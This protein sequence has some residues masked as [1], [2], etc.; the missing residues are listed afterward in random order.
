MP[1]GHTVHRTAND[2]TRKF[3]GK[4]LVIDSPQGRF[5]ADAA[6]VS[7]QVLVSAK[8]IGKQLF[9]RFQNDLVLRVHLG[10]YG[11]WNWVDLTRRSEFLSEPPKGQVRARFHDG[12]KLAELRGPTVCEVVPEEAAQ[13]VENRLG[14]DPINPDPTGSEQQRFVQRVL[15]SGQPIG[16]L[17]MDQSV[18][19]GVGNVYRA[20]LLFRAGLDPYMPG[21]S[22]PESVLVRLWEDSVKLL[23]VGVRH[24][25]MITRDELFDSKPLKAERNFVYKREGQGC[26]ECGTEVAIALMATRKLYWCPSCQK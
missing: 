21:R 8:A 10:I 22:V 18:L 3:A 26:R 11:K 15:R 23:A 12:S 2:F 25:V 13:L 4:S 14:P 17:L 19:S 1:E 5:S 9:L 7:G 24:G 20:E 16:Q 6:L